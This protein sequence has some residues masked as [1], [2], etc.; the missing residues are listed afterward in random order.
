M[1]IDVEAK[2]IYTFTLD[3]RGA[4]ALLKALRD[5]VITDSTT[6][7]VRQTQELTALRE[8]LKEAVTP[9]WGNG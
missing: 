6:F 4:D 9:G 1:Q 5:D 2:K 3:Q 8:R 7:T